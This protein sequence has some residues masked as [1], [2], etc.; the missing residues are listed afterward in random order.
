MDE[1]KFE[2]GVGQQLVEPRKIG[3]SWMVTISTGHEKIN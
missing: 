1:P 2:A 3:W